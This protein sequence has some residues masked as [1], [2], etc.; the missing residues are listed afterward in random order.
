[1]ACTSETA[2]S[3]WSSVSGPWASETNA[4]MPWVSA[5]SPVTALSA[6]GMVVS[7]RGSI[8]ETSG[9]SAL[10]MIVILVCR[11]VSVTMQNWER[12]PPRCPT[13]TAA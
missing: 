9:T 5:S 10:R 3:A 4:S 8:T 13:W 12:R 6:S 1:L 11:S 2:C 7:S